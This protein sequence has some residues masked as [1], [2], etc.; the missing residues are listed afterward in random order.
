MFSKSKRFDDKGRQFRSPVAKDTICHCMQ[1][2]PLPVDPR[3]PLLISAVPVGPS[4][5]A[6]DVKLP[7]QG[8][9]GPTTFDRS[10]RWEKQTESSSRGKGWRS[11]WFNPAHLPPCSRKLSLSTSVQQIL[12]TIGICMNVRSFSS[13]QRTSTPQQMRA[14]L[15]L[16]Q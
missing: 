16:H 6:Y 11:V 2:A 1:P 3:L 9:M 7:L 14:I 15:G 5:G 8:S 4:V 10:R 12:Q 13:L